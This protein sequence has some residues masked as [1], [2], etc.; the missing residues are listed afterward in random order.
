MK[1]KKIGILATDETA[2]YYKVDLAKSLGSRRDLATIEKNLFHS[3]REFDSEGVDIIIAEG[4]PPKGLGLAVM[5]RLRKASGYK[6]L[7][8]DISE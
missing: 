4:I 8:A 1:G 7:K 3:L 2:E 6:I 5:N